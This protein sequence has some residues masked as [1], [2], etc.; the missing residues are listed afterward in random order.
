MQ[1]SKKVNPWESQRNHSVISQ[2][3]SW[4]RVIHQIPQG[5]Y[6]SFVWSKYLWFPKAG[7]SMTGWSKQ[8]PETRSHLQISSAS[9][10]YV[11]RNN[12]LSVLLGCP[13]VHHRNGALHTKMLRQ[14]YFC[15]DEKSDVQRN[16]KGRGQ[17]KEESRQRKGVRLEHGLFLFLGSMLVPM[18][19]GFT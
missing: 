12:A 2:Q 13:F 18:T 8:L 16:R 1:T 5:C 6:S 19:M 3:L 17:E 10:S 11:T 7:S 9:T 4:S 15:P 14:A